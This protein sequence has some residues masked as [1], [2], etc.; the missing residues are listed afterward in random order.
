[1]SNESQHCSNSFTIELESILRFLGVLLE[2]KNSRT[3][4]HSPFHDRP[5]STRFVHEV[6]IRLRAYHSPETITN[7]H[8]QRYLTQSS[9]SSKTWTYATATSPPINSAP[10]VLPK[11]GSNDS[12]PMPPPGDGGGR[13]IALSLQ[14]R[15]SRRLEL[16]RRQFTVGYLKVYSSSCVAATTPHHRGGIYFNQGLQ[17]LV[18]RRKFKHSP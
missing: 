15:S 13:D 17:G 14:L 9:S 12:S 16:D 18:R 8:Q 4:T 3:G 6:G 11:L 7:S 10:S 1:M 5:V 2:D